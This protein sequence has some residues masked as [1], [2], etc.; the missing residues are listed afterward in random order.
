MLGET[1]SR[2]SLTRA[3]L[4]TCGRAKSNFLLSVM[5]QITR[6][7]DWTCWASVVIATFALSR[8]AV[9]QTVDAFNPQ[10]DRDI[11]ALAVQPDGKVLLGGKFWEVKWHPQSYLARVFPD[12]SL[13][14][15]FNPTLT[16]SSTQV[17]AAGVQ[18]DGKVLVAGSFTTLCGQTCT[19]LGR[20]NAD[21]TRDGTFNPLPSYSI[22]AL[23]MQADGKILLGG[24]FAKLGDESCIGLA[25]IHANGTFDADFGAVADSVVYALALQ[26]DGKILV[27]GNFWNLG[28]QPCNKFGRLHANGT[29]D[30]SFNPGAN[31]AVLCMAVQPDGKIVVGGNFTMLGGQARTNLGRLHANGTLDESFDPQAN[32]EVHTLALHT[33]GKILV[34]GYFTALGG[35]TRKYLGRLDANGIVDGAFNPGANMAVTALQ[36]QPDGKVVV[37]GRFDRLAGQPRTC[38]GRLN[39]TEPATQSLTRDGNT[40]TWLRGGTSPE[41]WRTTF[42]YSTNEV[43]WISLGAGERITGGWQRTGVSAPANAAIRAR[44]YVTGGSANASTWFAEAVLPLSPPAPPQIVFDDGHLGLRSNRFGFH[45]TGDAGST[46]VIEATTDLT[47]WTSLQT[48]TLQH[49]PLYFSE[50]GTTNFSWRFYRARLAY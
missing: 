33:D 27:S 45:L 19:Y 1:E 16:G 46:V 21:G 38:L 31:V 43:D 48:N 23:A 50:P 26:P 40:L 6:K 12:G 11:Y 10:P 4:S 44:G 15:G 47:S 13:E 18:P 22:R 8:S 39:N 32:D 28:G 20:L 35:H 17:E 25:R 49:T 36:V 9:P 5:N 37:G 3:A 42:E 2:F 30:E 14:T 34:G 24:M 41:V 7:Q 29:R